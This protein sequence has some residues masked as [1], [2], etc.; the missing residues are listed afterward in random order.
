MATNKLFLTNATLNDASSSNNRLVSKV[1]VNR[2]YLISQEIAGELNTYVS[3]VFSYPG[4]V[5]ALVKENETII[6]YL[7]QN[8]TLKEV[9]TVPV[10]DG[11]TIEVVDGKI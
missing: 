10:G 6:Y 7:D 1:R 5:L 2:E 4:Q 3:G 8:K 11:K 9:G